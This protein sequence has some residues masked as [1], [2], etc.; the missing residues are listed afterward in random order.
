MPNPG[1]CQD[2]ETEGGTAWSIFGSEGYNS[3]YDCKWVVD[4]HNSY[5]KKYNYNLCVYYSKYYKAFGKTC[6][7]ACCGCGGGVRKNSNNSNSNN[8][9]SSG[10]CEGKCG[11]RC[12]NR[13]GK[14]CVCG[15]N[16]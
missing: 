3:G 14:S 1:E 7:D 10:T 8:N 12:G 15:N 13:G 6:S 11:H 2:W 4:Y 9:E 16:R 5:M